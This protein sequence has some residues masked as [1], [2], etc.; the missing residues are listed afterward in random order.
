MPCLSGGKSYNVMPLLS[1]RMRPSGDF[2]TRS[3]ALPPAL[4]EAVR[5]AASASADVS[6]IQDVVRF[7]AMA[8]AFPVDEL[9][10]GEPWPRAASSRTPPCHA[11]SS[12][13]LCVGLLVLR[14]EQPLLLD[15]ARC[16][17]CEPEVP[18]ACGEL[19]TAERVGFG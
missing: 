12:A 9:G 16:D 7:E 5:I 1:T 19:E 3:V 8:P 11:S 14:L 10:R 4:A 2:A 15:D 6:A 18:L 13:A 17:V